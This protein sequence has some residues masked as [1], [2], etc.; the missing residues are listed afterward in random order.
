MTGFIP[1]ATDNSSGSTS[2]QGHVYPESSKPAPLPGQVPPPGYPFPVKSKRSVFP[3]LVII[4]G[5]IAIVS[6]SLALFFPW[7]S[8]TTEMD[9]MGAEMK[10]EERYSFFGVSSEVNLIGSSISYSWDEVDEL[11][12]KLN[13]LR[14]VYWITQVLVIIGFI[15]SILLM[16]GGI[17]L[18]IK[19]LKKL[20]IIISILAFV[21]CLTAPIFFAAAHP[22]AYKKDMK[23]RSTIEIDSGPGESFIGSDEIREDGGTIG[24]SSKV[25]MSWGPSYGWYLAVIGFIS[26]LLGFLFAFFS[27]VPIGES[28]RFGQPTTQF[29]PPPHQ[30]QVQP[31]SQLPYGPAPVSQPQVR[32]VYHVHIPPPKKGRWWAMIIIG[33][34][35]FIIAVLGLILTSYLYLEESGYK[36]MS[37]IEDDFNSNEFETYEDGDE[38]KI[39]GRITSTDVLSSS[40]GPEGA[41]E[42]YNYVYIVDYKHSIPIYSSDDFDQM[43]NDV[44]LECRVK[45][46]TDEFGDKTEYLVASD[47]Q[48]PGASAACLV[49]S[50][51]I[52]VIGIVLILIGVLYL[53]KIRKLP[54]SPSPIQP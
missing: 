39:R 17:L 6:L 9:L 48:V 4:C 53:R 20:V 3:V 14:E 50:I 25:T 7:Y 54:P 29:I 35:L 34:I 36:R 15:M 45:E 11:G 2:N 28:Q 21:L 10:T 43:G 30:A 49:V 42:Q 22:G 52:L 16:F 33:V 47:Y 41:S 8:I 26:C 24:L 18:F 32:T 46:G 19:R 1:P 40:E 23:D 12:M 31:Q 37:E 44:I 5:I 38:I 51:I 27:K 13:N